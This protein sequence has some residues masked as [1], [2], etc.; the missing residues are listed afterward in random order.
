MIYLDLGRRERGKTTLAVYMARKCPYQVIF[1][2][3]GLVRPTSGVRVKNWTQ[4]NNAAGR[5]ADTDPKQHITEIIVTPDDDPHVLFDRTARVVKAWAEDFP[6]RAHSMMFVVDE[7]RFVKLQGSPAFGW[8]LRASP[9]ELFH[10]VITAHRPSDIPT[11][12]RAIADHWL[13]FRSTQ[14]HDLAV[15]EDRCG[16][17]VAREV[18]NLNAFEYVHWDDSTGVYS[19]NKNPQS[20][21]I[22]LRPASERAEEVLPVE[23]ETLFDRDGL[24]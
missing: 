8:I 13:L 3:R 22:A 1:D 17:R 7:A 2:P 18:R 4:L 19:V 20:W 10:V 16:D 12:I 14:E 21:F 15:I 9:R 5:M 23:S 24:F 6:D 11:D